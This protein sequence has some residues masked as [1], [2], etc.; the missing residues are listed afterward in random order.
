VRTNRTLVTT[1]KGSGTVS[2]SVGSAFTG[3][4]DFGTLAISC[5]TTLTVVANLTAVAWF[6]M[7][8]GLNSKSANLSTLKTIL[9]VQIIPWFGATFASA[10]AV[11]LLLLPR[12]FRGTPTG[13]SQFMVWY[14]LLTV[15]VTKAI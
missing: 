2:V 11:P 15:A 13:P 9:F 14:P 4:N 6:G 7:W 5:A 1:T 8:M 12:L 3:P 10:L